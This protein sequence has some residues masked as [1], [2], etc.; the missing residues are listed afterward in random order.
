[1]T[2]NI[3]GEP[4]GVTMP[5]ERGCPFAPP[6]AY[7]ALREQ[8][9]ISRIRLTS[10]GEAWWVSG[11]A[12]ARAILADHRFSSDKRRD[13]WPLYTLDAATL[14]QLRNQPPLM[15]DLDGAEHSAIRRSVIGEFTVRRLAALRPRDDAD[16]SRHRRV[17]RRRLCVLTAP[18]FL[19]QD[20]DGVVTGLSAHSDQQNA[21]RVRHAVDLCPSRALSVPEE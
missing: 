4:A 17:H 20:D 2:E 12:E 13:G 21:A 11:Y 9:P 19:D 14:Q 15:L 18:A 5:R 6:A 16:Q 8:A 3:A 10:G 7:E 1:M